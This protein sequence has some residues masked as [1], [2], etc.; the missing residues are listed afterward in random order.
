MCNL[1]V[2]LARQRHVIQLNDAFWLVVDL[3]LLSTPTPSL[4]APKMQPKS[5]AHTLKYETVHFT[6]WD[7]A[8]GVW[9]KHI[10]LKR[11]PSDQVQPMCTPVFF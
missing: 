9:P 8:Q 1:L 3:R 2:N 10:S 5:V 6:K 11:F 7:E 4:C